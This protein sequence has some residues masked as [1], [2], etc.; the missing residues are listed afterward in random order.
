MHHAG[1]QSSPI[2]NNISEIGCNL[3]VTAI[4]VVAFINE[5]FHMLLLAF[6]N[7]MQGKYFPGSGVNTIGFAWYDIS[8]TCHIRIRLKFI[9]CYL[10]VGN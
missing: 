8:K 7:H 6:Y 1:S 9:H 2:R 3:K 5:M 10:T 4:I